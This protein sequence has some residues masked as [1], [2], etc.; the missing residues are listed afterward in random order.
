[1]HTLDLIYQRKRSKETK[2]K[3]ND[4]NELIKKGLNWEWEGEERVNN[5]LDCNK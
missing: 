1:M 3:L 5:K 2:K 4:I